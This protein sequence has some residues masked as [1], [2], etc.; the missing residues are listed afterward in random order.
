L[1]ELDTLLAGARQARADLQQAGV[2]VRAGFETFDERIS[3][4]KTAIGRLQA[5]TA[6]TRHAQG[7]EIERLA[8]RGLEDRKQRLDS[9]LV[10]A[11][12]ALAQTYDSALNTRPATDAGT[13]Q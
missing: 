6:S 10:Q 9:Y 13:A 1:T 11:R 3:A 8:V 2:G 4:G 12:F 5:R 7:G